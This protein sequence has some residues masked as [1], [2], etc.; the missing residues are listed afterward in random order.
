VISG[1]CWHER[2]LERVFNLGLA[3]ATTSEVFHAVEH[4]ITTPPRL[5]VYGITASDLNDARDEPH[6]PRALMNL[7]DVTTWVQLRPRAREWCLRQYV[8]GRCQRLWS[9]WHFR[10]GIRLWA[11]DRLETL[12]PGICPETAAEARSGLRFNMALSTDGFAPRPVF[13]GPTLG[14]MKAAGSVS[15]RFH[16]LEN[17][18]LGGHLRYLQ[19]LLDWAEARGVEV[20]LLDMPVSDVLEDHMHAPAFTAYRQALADVEQTRKVRVVRVT[21][22]TAGLTDDDFGDLIHLNPSGARKLS[23]WLRDM[24]GREMSPTEAP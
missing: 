12:R 10:N 13:Q 23:L 8:R 2:P 15:P 21:R 14:Q 1:V 11:A 20:I 6:G 18:R 22:Q 24:L 7:R 3:G 19:R 16:F 5:L 17:Y 4:G 9:L